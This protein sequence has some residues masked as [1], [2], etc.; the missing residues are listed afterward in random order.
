MLKF[1]E[2]YIK[3]DIFINRFTYLVL[4]FILSI[5]L[6]VFLPNF[7]FILLGWD[8][9]G[10]TSFILVVYYQNSKSLGA[11]IVTALTNRIGD[12]MLLLAIA[13]TVNLGH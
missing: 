8:G 9:L 10:I 3:D 12:V 4:A 2:Y 6:L 11:G 5:N 7:I 1:S 13:I